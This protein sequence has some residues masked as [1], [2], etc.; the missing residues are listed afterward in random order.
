MT[1]NNMTAD[2]NLLAKIES[3]LVTCACMSRSSLMAA[4][5]RI[6][7]AL[8][9]EGYT[10]ECSVMTGDAATCGT[11]WHNEDA[12]VTVRRVGTLIVPA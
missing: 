6:D 4:C 12:G 10:K 3:N 7:A 9:S 2:A 5:A 1:N 11:I 8:V